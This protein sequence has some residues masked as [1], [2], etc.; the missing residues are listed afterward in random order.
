MVDIKK[1]TDA[2]KDAVSDAV[3]KAEE[4]AGDV[5]EKAE[6]LLEDRGGMDGIKEDLSEVKDIATGEGSL[7]DKAKAAMNALK[8]PAVGDAPEVT[9]EA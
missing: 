1:I 5:K 9:P 6:G 8:A 4:L 2:V 7:T 3:D